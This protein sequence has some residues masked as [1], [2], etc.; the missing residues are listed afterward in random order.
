VAVEGR[1]DRGYHTAAVVGAPAAPL[2]GTAAPPL[3]RV[4]PGNGKIVQHRDVVPPIP[5]RAANSNS[6][7]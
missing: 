4:S 6:M 2:S 5:E 1:R 3:D 7:F